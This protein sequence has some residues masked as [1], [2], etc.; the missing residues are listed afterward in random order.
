MKLKKLVAVLLTLFCIF[1]ATAC[2]G[3]TDLPKRVVSKKTETAEFHNGTTI[4]SFYSFNEFCNE[5]QV[6]EKVLPAYYLTIDTKD[7]YDTPFY[8]EPP[9]RYIVNQHDEKIFPTLYE[10]VYWYDFYWKHLP[11]QTDYTE[12]G[13]PPFITEKY[14]YIFSYFF[15]SY[16]LTTNEYNFT[17][18]HV[19]CEETYEMDLYY[20][21]CYKNGVELKPVNKKGI[22]VYNNGEL[23]AKFFYQ[24]R[25]KEL[26]DLFFMNFLKDNLVIIKGGG[27]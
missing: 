19:I 26:T 27:I 2:E 12:N 25:F 10:E 16:P 15:Y 21:E 3:V 22:F 7:K 23:V 1:T 5:M 6:N 18:E 24:K 14:P 13:I 9:K 8:S 4:F 11:K 20:F 17:F